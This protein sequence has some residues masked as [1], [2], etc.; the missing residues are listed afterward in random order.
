MTARILVID[1]DALIR[2]MFRFY[3]DQQGHSVTALDGGAA[4]VEHCRQSPP[5]LVMCDL[6]MPGMDGLTVL[7]EIHAA[8]PGL[9][10]IVISGTG[11]MADAI[12]ALKLGAADFLTKPI[13]DFAVLD[14]AVGKALERARLEAENRAYRASLEATNARLT[15]T[16]RQL[17]ADEEHGRQIQ[18]A[19][20]PE[21]PAR[22]GAFELSRFI[23]PSTFLSGDFVDYFSIDANHFGFYMADVAGHGVPSAVIT[24]LLKGSV[25]RHLENYRRFG[26][27]T[28]T[29]PAALLAAL[30]DEFLVARYGKHLTMFYGVIGIA[31]GRLTCANAGQYPF[32]MLTDDAGL[33]EIGGRSAPVG[34]F[35]GAQYRS[36]E[37]SFDGEG[38]LRLFS[39]GALEL[40]P[41]LSLQDRKE[42]LRALAANRELDAEGLA[43][44]LGVWDK[45]HRPDDVSVLSLRRIAPA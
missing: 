15:A 29:S 13:E 9:P 25:G 27:T 21:S 44:G 34:L 31:D 1:D 17:E 20:L 3:L 22:F 23:A 40:I 36:E 7:R 35:D 32:P 33:R 10:V 28:I 39:D 41:L 24:V 2:E 26:D 4:A 16:L 38:A 5:D 8:V 11:D 45:A 37:F 19:L 30:N 6:R 42:A 14:H 43:A 12:S 18:F